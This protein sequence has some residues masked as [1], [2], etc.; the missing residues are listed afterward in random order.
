MWDMD[1]IDAYFRRIQ[2]TVLLSSEHVLSPVTYFQSKTEIWIVYPLFVGGPLSHLLASHYV[3]GMTDEDVV[4]TIL[5]D[6]AEGLHAMHCADLVHCNIRPRNLHMVCSFILLLEA[7]NC[8][9]F[10]LSTVSML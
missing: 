4:A 2:Q 1:D 7:F 8:F 10:D 9:L 3:N 5:Y 6:V